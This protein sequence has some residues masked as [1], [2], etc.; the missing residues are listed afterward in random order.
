MPIDG[1][2][3]IRYDPVNKVLLKDY[4]VFNGKPI[5]IP[6]SKI[7]RPQIKRYLDLHRGGIV[8]PTSQEFLENVKIYAPAMTNYVHDQLKQPLLEKVQSIMFVPIFYAEENIGHFV[9][10]SNQE[11][12]YMPRHLQLLKELSIQAAVAMKWD[13]LYGEM[14]NTVNQA[15]ESE[16]LKDQFMA[17]SVHEL[18]TPLTSIQGYLD[19]LNEYSS[20]MSKEAKERMIQHARRSCNE[21]ILLLGNIMDTSLVDQDIINVTRGAVRIS[22]IIR[23]VVEIV[24]PQTRK[25]RRTIEVDVSND[26]YV[27]TDDLR[28]RQILL[29][30]VSNALKYTPE[31]TMIAIGAT[32]TTWAELQQ[33]IA[34]GQTAADASTDQ[35]YIA[36]SV[37]DWGPG[38]APEDQPLLF[39]KFRRLKEAINSSQRG[40]GM[41][42]YLCRR[43]T[44]SLDGHIWLRSTGISGEGST[45]TVALPLYEQLP[46][47]P[48]GTTLP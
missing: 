31:E 2:F 26:L 48:R 16:Q 1:F 41:G 25:Q 20:T 34:S 22:D 9:A 36:I 47:L 18:R 23:T 24:E 33:Q 10:L 42:L 12:A 45:F 21:L 43:L 46:T 11:H 17:E 38:I 28:L 40:T 5:A 30:L 6:A 44:E 27:W 32:V 15:L 14:R 8:F 13:N 4:M 7:I 37:Q 3:I 35:N 19:L 39:G 29:N